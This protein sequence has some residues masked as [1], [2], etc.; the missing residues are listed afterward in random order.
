MRQSRRSRWIWVV[1]AVV[2]VLLLL[3]ALRHRAAPSTATTAVPAYLAE[4]ASSGTFVGSVAASGNTAAAALATVQSPVAGS[5]TTLS[6]HQ[7][8]TVASGATIATLSNGTTIT[9]PIAGTVVSVPLTAGSYVTQGTTVATIANTST[10][11]ADVNVP[12]QYIATVKVGQSASV[13]L[14]ALPNQTFNGTV[15]EVG[16][17]GS[18]NTNG[19]VQFPV[20]IKL[21]RPT[22]VLIG[23]T[24]NALIHT[25]TI[26]HAVWVPTA[27]LTNVNGQEAVLVPARAL[28][29]PSFP[30][31]F[32]GGFG[33]GGFGGGGQRG[34]FGLF[35]GFR[36]GFGTTTTTLTR[37]VRVTVGLSNQSDTQIV[38]GLSAGQQIL[39]PNPAAS[40][41]TVGGAGGGGGFRFG[42]G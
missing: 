18:P 25:G 12:E 35:G 39:V 26:T 23:L 34:G 7:G 42:G 31:A 2:V 29:T 5:L 27:A 13:T 24:A 8:Q 41:T 32:G 15:T 1:V 11:Y 37:S 20:T 10:I 33:G 38:S 4:R 16:E 9:S 40:A 36:R 30:G 14:P 22:G 21:T 3:W 17:Q 6:V 19:I 28:P